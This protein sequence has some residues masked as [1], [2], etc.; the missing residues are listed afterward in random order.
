MG[1]PR[2]VSER[3]DRAL[4]EV[5]TLESRRAPLAV[6]LGVLLSVLLAGC[7]GGAGTAVSETTTSARAGTSVEARAGSPMPGCPAPSPT[8]PGANESGLP[9]RSL[10]ALPPE[11]AD[12][13]QKI[14]T[15][16]KLP[17]P[18]D[19]IVFSNAERLLPAR[20]RGY[21]HEYTV[22]T[23]GERDRGARRLVTG[24]SKEVYYT[25]DH[26]ESFVVVDSTATT[27]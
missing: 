17:Y 2:P 19:G 8:A 21:Y 10:C 14:K 24:Q 20:Q 9:L 12:T 15:G 4:T 27:R 13:W 5:P 7:S 1:A 11:A 16:A 25:A 22:P 3:A 18:R 6:L 23:P 26:Y